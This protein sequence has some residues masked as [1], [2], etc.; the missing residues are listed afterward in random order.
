MCKII[1]LLLKVRQFLVKSNI[2]LV[3]AFAFLGT[4]I[5][6]F[7]G[8]RKAFKLL[9]T[10][11]KE[12]HVSTNVYCRFLYNI[13]K[14]KYTQLPINRKVSKPNIV[15][16]YN[17]ILLRNWKKNELVEHTTWINCRNHFLKKKRHKF[18]YTVLFPVILS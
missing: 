18:I 5:W 12:N 16:S 17:G 14:L 2:S 10:N 9:C 3:Y 15:Y 8:T 7:I 13:L 6:M 11:M 4:Y 1:Q